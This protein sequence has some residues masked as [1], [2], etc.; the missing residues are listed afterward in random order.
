[1]HEL[2][3]V[4]VI[5]SDEHNAAYMGCAGHPFIKTPNLDRLSRRGVRFS[6]AYTPSPICVPARAAF[7]TGMRVHQTRHWDNATPYIGE[8][9][10]WGHA[11]QAQHIRVESIGKL[12]YRSEDD[13]VGFDV[14][15]IPMHVVGGHGMVWASIRDPYITR[16]DGKRMLGDRIGAGE[17]SY[18]DYDRA[19][20]RQ[21]CDWLQA[22]SRT[23]QPFVLYVGLVAPHFPLIAPEAFYSLYDAK[24][25]PPAKLHPS[26]GHIRHPWVNEYA[27][28]ERTEETFANKQERIN[29]FLAYYG[30]CSFLDD[31]VGQI[32]DALDST[33]LSNTTHVIYTSDHGDNVGARGLWGKSTLY[34]ES[35]GIPL[36][37]AGPRVHAG[38]CETPVD[39]LDLYPTILD[40]AGA[41][42]CATMRNRPGKSLLDIV[43]LPPEPTRPILSE[44]HAAGSNTAGFMLRR[45]RWKYHHYVRFEPELFDLEADPE[46][47]HNLAN[48]P[49]HASILQEMRGAL[50]ALCDPEAIDAQAKADQ[51]KL[52]DSL[53]GMNV[54]ASMGASGATP[55]PGQ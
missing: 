2:K 26:K 14:Q 7:A 24:Q 32:I 23:R 21:A 12:H 15:H 10:S 25:I 50:Y 30:L 44:Y 52:I 35:V 20:T 19:V 22:A 41:D 31:N 34:Q 46:E 51:K 36:I 28:F 4:V 8:P 11:L 39:L 29:A 43:S 1:M 47:L 6:S 5:M 40:M 38:T 13:D 54:A 53:G 48:D 37:V 27:A 33:G 55:V 17:S 42:V 9:D 49:D 16:G 18:T 45:G 3:N